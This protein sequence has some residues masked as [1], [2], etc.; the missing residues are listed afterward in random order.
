[1]SAPFRLNQ[2][3]RPL[4]MEKKYRFQIRVTGI[5]IENDKLLLVRQKVNPQRGWSLPGGRLEQQE[6]IED[7]II[8]EIYE[9]TG[10]RTRLLRL[11]YVAEIPEHQ[12]I[13]MTFQLQK[14][15]GMLRL[16]SN[17]FDANPISDVKFAAFDEL[18][19]YG[20]SERFQ[21]LVQNDFPNAGSYAGLKSQIGL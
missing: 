20:F 15:D 18:V 16:P 10:L 12:L 19:Q 5:V 11:L 7:A 8:R 1:M 6:T 17:E 14:I 9:E 21:A 2:L 4:V 3:D 13:H